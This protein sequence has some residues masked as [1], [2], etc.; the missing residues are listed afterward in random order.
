MDVRL[1]SCWLKDARE[2][3]K[4]EVVLDKLSGIK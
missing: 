3:E 2:K 1:A 4:T